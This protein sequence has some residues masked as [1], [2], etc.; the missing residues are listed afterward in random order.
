[1][2]FFPVEQPKTLVG[3]LRV[4]EPTTLLDLSGLYGDSVLRDTVTEVGSATVTFSGG[5]THLTTTASGGDSCSVVSTERVRF[6]A[7]QQA[8]IGMTGRRA[9]APTGNQIYHAGMF[10]DDNGLG[11]GEDATGP[12]IFDRIGGVETKVYSSSWN[13]DTMDGTG[14]S[15]LTADLSQ[16]AYLIVDFDC[17]CYGTAKFSLVVYNPNTGANESVC[18]HKIRKTDSMLIENPN[19]PLQITVDNAGTATAFEVKFGTRSFR[20]YGPHVPSLRLTGDYRLAMTPGTTF[21][22]TVSF[23]RKSAFGQVKVQIDGFDAISDSDL[24]VQIRINGSLTGA[25]Y[26]TPANYSANETAV[27]ADKSATAITGGEVV[28]A[29][30]IFGGV[31]NNEKGSG[32]AGLVDLDLPNNQPV[33][34]CVR[35][36]TGTATDSNFVF[37]MVEE[38]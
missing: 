22:P 9:V 10:D 1:M 11:F 38:W 17:Y 2:T 14:P 24:L 29:G 30:L 23:R 36:L 27:E 21:I 4:A 8:S 34:L 7:G 18:V 15:G 25:S 13:C 33:T 32:S 20:A 31:K 16:G 28:W 3:D 5:E 12:F 37:R 6:N 26:A 19:V 35:T